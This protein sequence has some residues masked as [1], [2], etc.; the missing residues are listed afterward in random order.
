MTAAGGGRRRGCGERVT[1]FERGR[2]GLVVPPSLALLG[3]TEPLS[4]G[5]LLMM[6]ITVFSTFQKSL[7]KNRLLL[8]LR[9]LFR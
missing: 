2:E 6:D 9:R 3:V 1:G 4:C 7:I 5:G 8:F